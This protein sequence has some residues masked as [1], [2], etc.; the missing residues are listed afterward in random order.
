MSDKSRVGSAVL[1]PTDHPLRSADMIGRA[2][3]V[4]RVALALL[5]G[6]NV[7]MAGPR[8][9]GKT[10]VADAAL[11]VCRKEAAYTAK[12]DL[13]DCSD[14]GTLAHLL[15][16]E[17]LANRPPLR[18]AI[19]DAVRGGRGVVGALRTSATLRARQDLGDDVE[20][21]IDIGVA[22][23]EP[24]KALDS[25]LRLAQRLAERDK[26][27]VVVFFD[28]FQDITRVRFGDSDTLTRRIRAVFQRSRDVSVL[29]A[30]SI[31]HLMRDLFGPTERA[32]SQFGAFQE[33]SA[34]TTEEWAGGICNR[35]ALD[36]TT[37]ST[38]ALT[39]LL[40]LGEGHPR[41]TM[42]IAQQ[43]H[44]QA[45]EELRHEIDHALVVAALDR[46]LGA[47]QLRHQQQLE[48]IR[49]SSRY[50]ERMAIR[51]A[52]GAELYQGL[53]PEQA[54]RALGALRDISVVERAGRGSWHV[55]DP[56]LRRY[57][58]ARSSL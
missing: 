2:G 8:R 22:E 40:E 46:A 27:R 43:A 14:A 33:L 3:D 30:G 37:I 50:G 35:L 36:H 44:L 29:F 17:L 34:I 12:V 55:I 31:E 10:T 54:S 1:F 25:A 47:E 49:S 53:K 56:L 51:V 48:R 4:D 5:G 24:L 16:L 20:I 7:V 52:A 26:R 32:L 38:D 23:A 9:I 28:E 13:F 19:S 42:L 58:A 11:E 21:T 6:A 18:R 57:L 41:A 45:I 39:R 15:A